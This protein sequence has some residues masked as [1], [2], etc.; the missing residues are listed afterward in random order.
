MLFSWFCLLSLVFISMTESQS[1]HPFGSYEYYWSTIQE[2]Y[3]ES[4]T[5]AEGQC[6]QMNATLAIVNTREVGDYFDKEIGNVTCKQ[7]LSAL[8]NCREIA[9]AFIYSNYF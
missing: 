4:Y 5:E 2:D 1:F 7:K 6:R 9:Q 3:V 8:F